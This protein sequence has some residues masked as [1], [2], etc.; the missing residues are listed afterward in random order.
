MQ[1]LALLFFVISISVGFAFIG[2][3]AYLNIKYS[4]PLLRYHL[5]QL[6]AYS[7]YILLQSVGIYGFFNT[8]FFANFQLV[9]IVNVTGSL[10]FLG[11]MI[12]YQA[13]AFLFVS[14]V[15]WEGKIRL[16]VILATLPLVMG[17]LA[18]FENNKEDERLAYYVFTAMSS[19]VLAQLICY[20]I[21]FRS[22]RKIEDELRKYIARI[23]FLLPVVMIPIALVEGFL[24]RRQMISGDY[25]MG[26]AGQPL[27]YLVNNLLSLLV[28]FKARNMHR[29]QGDLPTAF[30]L[31][32]HITGREA[33]IIAMINRGLSNKEIASKLFLAPST[34]R[35]HISNIFE[36][37][38]VNGRTRLLHLIHERYR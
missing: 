32:F 10:F 24:Q 38:G 25:P 5:I 28:L 4:Y 1:H 37:I 36:K 19:F 27:I 23:L 8:H 6:T 35:N 14:G 22:Y 31:E 18:L 17:V 20:T 7:F 16:F 34:V 13:R 26:I 11:P 21:L 12:Y 9:V 29:E 30:L 3:F 2:L 15:T 33:E